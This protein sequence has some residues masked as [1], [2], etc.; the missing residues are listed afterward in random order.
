MTT[1][2]CYDTYERHGLDDWRYSWG[3]AVPGGTDLTVRMV[4]QLG[5][6][7]LRVEGLTR[8]EVIA[9][10]LEDAVADCPPGTELHSVDDTVAGVV[11]GI[12]APELHVRAMMT[13]A[14]IADVASVT[15]D[16]I[17]AYKYRGY[18]PLPQMTIARTPLWAR[19]IVRRWMASR[20]GLGWRTD[21][22]GDRA[23]YI[24]TI[25]HLRATRRPPR[26]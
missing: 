5:T 17:S 16:T 7:G 18:L 2:L 19:P 9:R 20:P 3:D 25:A 26:D 8:A 6:P 15:A 4:M 14:D 21:L 13:I 10:I 24:E 23:D 12:L 1:M 22:Y 11:V